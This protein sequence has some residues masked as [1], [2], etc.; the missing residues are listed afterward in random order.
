M[1][2]RIKEESQ[3]ESNIKETEIGYIEPMAGHTRKCQNVS[4]GAILWVTYSIRINL[5]CLTLKTITLTW[6]NYY[7]TCWLT[8][9]IP[10]V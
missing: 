5:V 7:C 6:C 1:L 3:I 2:K 10:I 8:P 9:N 4:G